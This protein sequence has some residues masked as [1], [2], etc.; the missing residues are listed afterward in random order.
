MGQKNQHPTSWHGIHQ[1]V[2]YMT[3]QNRYNFVDVAV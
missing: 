2:S 1:T 3:I